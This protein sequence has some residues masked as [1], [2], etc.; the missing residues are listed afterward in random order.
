MQAGEEWY[1]N[2]VK[3]TLLYEQFPRL[4][5]ACETDNADARPRLLR[6]EDLTPGARNVRTAS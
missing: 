5:M 4:W 1:F 6:A 3:F 2:G